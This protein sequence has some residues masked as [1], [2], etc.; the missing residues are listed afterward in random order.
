MGSNPPFLPY[1]QEGDKIPSPMMSRRNSVASY[2]SRGR[3]ESMGSRSRSPSQT[4]SPIA[5][6]PYFFCL[7]CTYPRGNQFLGGE[8]HDGQ[9]CMYCLESSERLAEEDCEVWCIAKDHN[10]PL[11][12]FFDDDQFIHY[13]C[14]QCQGQGVPEHDAFWT[15]RTPPPGSVRSRLREGRP[16]LASSPYLSSNLY[17]FL[18][19]STPQSRGRQLTGAPFAGAAER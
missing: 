13:I 18:S 16:G 9:Y 14:R 15:Q 1:N 17:S 10:L 5:P 6:K 8:D 19:T 3:V 11:R 7:M 2:R 12:Q 4:P